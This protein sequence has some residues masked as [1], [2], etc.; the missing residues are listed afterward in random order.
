MLSHNRATRPDSF[1]G[2]GYDK[3]RSHPNLLRPDCR[4]H[5]EQW[6]ITITA[7]EMKDGRCREAAYAA[8]VIEAPTLSM[9]S[10]I[11]SSL[12]M[13]GGVSSIV[14]PAGRIMIPASKKA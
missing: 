2:I 13:S 8:A 5:S 1:V 3:R 7:P 10:P 6:G 11:W 9:I 14:S 4:P 12:T